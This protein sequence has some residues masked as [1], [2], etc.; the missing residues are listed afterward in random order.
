MITSTLPVASIRTLACSQPPAPYVEAAEQLREGARPHISVNVE[1][2][3][4]SCTVSPESRRCFC[5]A[6]SSSYSNIALAFSVAA[7]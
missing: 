1:M 7:S 6:R 5:S 2:P 3:M 4:P